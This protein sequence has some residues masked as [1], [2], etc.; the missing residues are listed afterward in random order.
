[1]KKQIITKRGI[2]RLEEKIVFQE[3]E[4][5]RI[6]KEKEIAY[7]VSGDGW[8]DNPGF[9]NLMQAEEQAVRELQKLQFTLAHS[10]VWDEENADAEKVQISTVVRFQMIP[11]NGRPARELCYEIGGAGDTDLNAGIISYDSPI[12]SALLNMSPGEEKSITIP[13]GKSIVRILG[14]SMPD[15]GDEHTK[16]VS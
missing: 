15:A 7:E 5:A 11:A 16:K 6:R 14:I 3:A 13:A 8:H 10:I 12:G 2:K 9:N 4:I 1:M